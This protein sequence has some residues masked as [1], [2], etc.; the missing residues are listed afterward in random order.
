MV[1]R[2]VSLWT[3][4]GCLFNRVV[5]TVIKSSSKSVSCLVIVKEFIW[6]TVQTSRCS[7]SY[8][9]MKSDVLVSNH[10]RMSLMGT[11]PKTNFIGVSVVIR[12]KH[13]MKEFP[14]F[15]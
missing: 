14:S 15:F 11:F 1:L 12:M 6:S 4:A 3:C 13:P 5:L 8:L 10:V 9:L 7:V 2:S